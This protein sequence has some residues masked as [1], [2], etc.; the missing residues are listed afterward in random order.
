MSCHED[1]STAPSAVINISTRYYDDVITYDHCIID[2]I[3][4]CIIYVYIFYIYIV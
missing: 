4:I 1:A 3:F 2:Y